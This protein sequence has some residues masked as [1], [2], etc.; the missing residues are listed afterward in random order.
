[1]SRKGGRTTG[2]LSRQE[3]GPVCKSAHAVLLLVLLPLLLL[4]GLADVA[5]A[6]D[7]CG[8][9]AGQQ[10][11]FEEYRYFWARDCGAGAGHTERGR[12]LRSYGAVLRSGHVP[13]WDG[14]CRWLGRRC[15]RGRAANFGVLRLW[16]RGRGH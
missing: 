14:A 6:I 9:P 12:L 7:M 13:W 8:T 2:S 15:R 1:M 11:T 10:A 16:R 3:L 4:G 5:T